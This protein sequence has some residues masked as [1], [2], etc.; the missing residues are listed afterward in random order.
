MSY[1]TTGLTIMLKTLSSIDKKRVLLRFGISI[2]S[3]SV[4]ALHAT[5]FNINVLDVGER[6]KIDLSHFSD[7]DYVTPGEYLLS[8]R[9]NGREIQ[10]TKVQFLPSGPNNNKPTACITPEIVNKLALTKEA[11]RMI[12]LWN[13]DE[14]ADLTPISGVKIS[15]RIG[16]GDLDI[17]IPQ[18]WLR[19][20]DTNWTPPEQWDEGINGVLLDYNLVGT[21]RRNTNNMGSDRYLSSYGAAGFN[22]GAWRYRADYRY[23][24]QQSRTTERDQFSWDQFYAYRPLP[25]M[26]ADLR[27]GEMFSGSNLFDSYRFTGIALENNENMLPPAM[28][29]YAPEICGVDRSNARV[30]VTQN[31]RVIH[32]TTVPAGPF[33]I[34]SLRSGISGTLNVEVTEEDG[35]VSRFQTEA[36]NLPYLTRPGH[37]Q[38]KL[39]D[40]RPSNNDHHF[41]GPA[42]SSAEAS[43]GLS[44]S[45]S[46]YGDTLLSDSYQSWAAGVG[47]TS[48]CWVHSRRG[49][50]TVTRHA[51]SSTLEADG[52]LFFLNWSKLFDSI[53]SQVSFA[54][55]R[56]SERT[57]MSMP[58]LLS[59]LNYDNTPYSEKERYS[60]TVSKNFSAENNKLLLSCMS[61][62]LTYTHSTF[63]NASEQDR[64]G[65]SLNK[66]FDF[67]DIKG[68]SANLSAYKT[69]YNQH[70]DD[71][72]YLSLSI[73]LRDKE[74]VSYVN[75]T[76]TYTNNRASDSNWNLSTRYNDQENT[77][78][79]GNYNYLASTTDASVSA[80]WQQNRYTFLSGSLRGLVTATQHGVAAHP[81]GNNGGTRIMVDTDGQ[82]DVPFAQSRV[83]TNRAGLAVIANTSSY[84]D[85]S[86]RIDVQKLPKN[87]E[88]TTNVVQGTLTEGAIGYRKFI[89]VSGAKILAS[90]MLENGKSPP[91]ASRIKNS[92]GRDVAM[93]SYQGQAYITGVSENEI[94]S[95][96]W[97]GKAQC[98]VTLPATLSYLD[99]LLLPC[100]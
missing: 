23:F 41:E 42:F 9:I 16:M 25:M 4:S 32:E 89:V 82:P 44:S 99:Q 63:W 37:V 39:S 13:N 12:V 69:T 2:F 22:L 92:K 78:L 43:W 28:R 90:I 50:H 71:S 5:E 76:L 53:E 87:I 27:L 48:I 45:W 40:G 58:Q 34:Q 17:T 3:L 49:C 24:R 29:G 75:Q 61:T 60:I 96:F 93:V 79:S 36:A 6:Q 51:G 64:Y 47:K 65:V 94:L 62:Y 57:F 31:G 67:G 95:V 20:S 74:R 46:V 7:P 72:I 35:S 88:A 59:A 52:T 83:T 77:Y 30:T 100:K 86:T 54:G 10:Q 21:A 70:T 55:Y 33:A 68:I 15:N 14:C 38:Y 97:E 66:Y 1:Q 81:K 80:A 19:Y 56:F 11:S 26:S 73:P 91:F 85:V 8:I 18:A 84:Y 98:Q